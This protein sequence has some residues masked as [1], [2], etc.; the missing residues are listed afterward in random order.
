M[1]GGRSIAA[2]GALGVMAA[3]AL[4]GTATQAAGAPGDV[5]AAGHNN[6]RDNWDPEEVPLRISRA[7]A[8]LGAFSMAAPMP[9]GIT[10]DP[11][12][13]LRQ[14]VTSSPTGPR[15]FTSRHLFN[16]DDGRGPVV[17]GLSGVG[18]R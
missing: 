6:L 17:V 13:Y 4:G 11:R 7:I 12:T 9:E 10:L 18:V 15:A 8:P 16:G 2:I 5:T 3:W 14:T 1:R